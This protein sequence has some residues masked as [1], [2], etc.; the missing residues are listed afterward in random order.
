MPSIKS[1][2]SNSG[3]HCLFVCMC[4]CD[5]NNPDALQ[6][7]IMWTCERSSILPIWAIVR[8]SKWPGNIMCRVASSIFPLYALCRQAIWVECMLC[9]SPFSLFLCRRV[10]QVCKKT[11]NNKFHSSFPCRTDR[12]IVSLWNF[13]HQFSSTCARMVVYDDYY[14]SCSPSWHCITTGVTK[15]SRTCSSSFTDQKL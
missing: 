11:E 10:L 15:L 6:C 12:H 8:A 4:E 9:A 5:G 13:Q 7:Y 1:S 3:R 14:T 2:Y